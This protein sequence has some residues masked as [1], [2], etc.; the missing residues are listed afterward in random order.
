MKTLKYIQASAIL[1]LM[2]LLFSWVGYYYGL[3]KNLTKDKVVEQIK[4]IS[5]FQ[6]EKDCEEQG[7]KF[8]LM[9]NEKSNRSISIIDGYVT[10][11]YPGNFYILCE[12]QSKF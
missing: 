10:Y 11:F 12:T 5:I 9:R 4:I 1:F 7:G 8:T 2:I 6:E 3:S